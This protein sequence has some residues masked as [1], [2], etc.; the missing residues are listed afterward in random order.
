MNP[1]LILKYG[2]REEGGDFFAMV[3][4]LG[5]SQ[6]I[7]VSKQVAEHDFWVE[8]EVSA[9]KMSMSLQ[10]EHCDFLDRFFQI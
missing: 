1:D 5:F 9:A 10:K 6:V 4:H 3:N 8:A 2:F 7:K